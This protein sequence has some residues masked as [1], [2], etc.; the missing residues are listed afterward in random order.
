MTVAQANVEQHDNVSNDSEAQPISRFHGRD[1][2]REM[3]GF[4]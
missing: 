1:A 2:D 3:E 4:P